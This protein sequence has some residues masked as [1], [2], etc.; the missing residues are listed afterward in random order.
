MTQA[1]WSWK[2][3]VPMGRTL[4]RDRSNTRRSLSTKRQEIGEIQE[5]PMECRATMAVLRIDD[6]RQ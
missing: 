5:Q 4:H 3:G 2:I 6:I 1:R